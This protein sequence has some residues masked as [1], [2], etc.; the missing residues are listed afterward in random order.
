MFHMKR[1]LLACLLAAW[2]LLLTPSPLLAQDEEIDALR[3][4]YNQSVKVDGSSGLTWLFLVGL[5]V[6]CFAVLFKDARR[7]HLD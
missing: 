4:G 7:T 2:L 3:Y 5:G 6:I 1:K